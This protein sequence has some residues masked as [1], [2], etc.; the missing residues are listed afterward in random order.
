M[1]TQ[2]TGGQQPA[3][4]NNNPYAPMSQSGPAPLP[5]VSP[6]PPFN[7]VPP[8]NPGPAVNPVPPINP[9]AAP[10]P[11]NPKKEAARAVGRAPQ[12]VFFYSLI[13]LVVSFAM[14]MVFLAVE[15]MS[16]ANGEADGPIMIA[17]VLVFFAL[18]L[19]SDRSHLWS[20][21]IGWNVG[22]RY[23]Q[24]TAVVLLLIVLILIA[25]SV[26]SIV[27]NVALSSLWQLFGQTY[28]SAAEDLSTG[29]EP[30]ML[31]VYTC[32]IGPLMEEIVCRGVALNALRSRGEVFAIIASALLFALMHGDA[33]QF[34]YTFPVGLVLGYVAYEYSI[35]WSMAVHIFNNLVLGDLIPRFL[36]NLP[37]STNDIITLTVSLAAFVVA[38]FI[39]VIK[40][41]VIAAFFKAHPT[42]KGSWEA[43][44]T[45][46]WFWALVALCLFTIFNG[47]S[48]VAQLI[49]GGAFIS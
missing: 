49:S 47:L 32:F 10:T 14:E 21:D 33:L 18:L 42:A 4:R 29:N 48:L 15:P 6:V 35:W 16:L 30:M 5:P 31:F 38:I 9:P 45:S 28:H 46:V 34:L 2:G 24:P 8:V 39:A 1:D 12:V 41:D 40:R 44:F 43:L 13:M 11:V 22:I 19:I 7:S 17:G 27:G 26:I 20:D 36:A 25:N 23:R 3:Q 37:N